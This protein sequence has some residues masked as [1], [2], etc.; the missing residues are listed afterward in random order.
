MASSSKWVTTGI[1][2]QALWGECQGSGSKPYQTQVDLTDIAFKCSCPSRKFPCKHGLGL[3]L[4]HSRQPGLFTQKEMPAW[5]SDWINKRGEKAEKAEKKTEQADKPIDETAQQ[6]RKQAREQKVNDGITDLLV[7]LKDIVRNGILSMP[8]KSA[9]YWDGMARR[10]VDAQASGLAAMVRELASTN[11]WQEGWQSSFMDKLTQLYTI[12]NAYQYAADLDELLRQDISAAIG[13]TVNQ[14]ELKQQAGLTDTWLVLGKEVTDEQQI[15]VERNWLYSINTGQCALVLQFIARVQ[16]GQ[17]ALSPGMFLEAELVFFPSTIPYRA[18]VKTHRVLS[19]VGHQIKPL[20][21]WQAVAEAETYLNSC[22]PFRSMVPVVVA[23]LKPVQYQ[24][25]WWLQDAYGD[26]C[27][28]PAGFTEIW[29][30]MTLSGGEPLT[31][32][33]IGSEGE[34][35]PLGVWYQRTYKSI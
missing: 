31:M 19:N 12:A 24:Q 2:P 26:L 30:L 9:A 22:L 13:F 6:K 28:L 7:W 29:P 32:A 10:M 34:Y 20:T 17:L 1:S 5:V 16:S 21:G 8:E 23:D 27:R 33:V 4:L 35:R 25:N 18:I 14:E 3:M 11:F 15:T